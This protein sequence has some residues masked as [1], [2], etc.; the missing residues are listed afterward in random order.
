MLISPVLSSSLSCDPLLP[1]LPTLVL[2]PHSPSPLPIRPSFGLSPPL[3]SLAC[4]FQLTSSPVT[5]ALPQHA[6]NSFKPRKQTLS[7]HTHNSFIQTK[8]TNI[9]STHRIHLSK[10][11]KQTLPQHTEFIHSNQGNKHSNQYIYI[12]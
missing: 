11:R 1:L 8:E 6:Q 9:P 3:P 7:Q 5:L 4:P 10:P 12:L 2:S